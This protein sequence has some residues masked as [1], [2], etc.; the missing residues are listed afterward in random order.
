MKKMFAL[1]LGLIVSLKPSLGAMMYSGNGDTTGG[2]AVGTGSLTLTDNGTTLFGTFTRG[3]GTFT[4]V[5]VIF[6]DL[7][8]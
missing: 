3:G 7:L 8:K 2:G 1:G 4:E 6:I 5:L